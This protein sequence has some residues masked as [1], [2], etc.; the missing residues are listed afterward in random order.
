[1]SRNRGV[2]LSP[3]KDR[4][5]GSGF[6]SAAAISR[7]QRREPKPALGLH[8]RLQYVE[9]GGCV[10]L[11]VKEPTPRADQH[12][13]KGGR[14][15]EALWIGRWEARFGN[16]ATVPNG[17]LATCALGHRKHGTNPA[18][19]APELDSAATKKSTHQQAVLG[20]LALGDANGTDSRRLAREDIINV[21]EAGPQ[22]R[23]NPEAW[24]ASTCHGGSVNQLGR[25]SRSR[26]G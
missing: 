8:G 15:R 5:A 13:D 24:V 18:W 12:V 20:S 1:M 19:P 9:E 11:R 16:D 14:I 25:E 22:R 21:V 17:A 26:R 10:P 4:K 23:A 7:A 3:K 2:Q 6:L